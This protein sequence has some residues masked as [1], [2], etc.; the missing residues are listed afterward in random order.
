MTTDRIAPHFVPPSPYAASIWSRG[1]WLY[2]SRATEVVM[3]STIKARRRPA[4]NGER[5]KIGAGTLNIQ[6]QSNQEFKD[7]AQPDAF[8]I[9]IA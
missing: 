4:I 3:G 6:I 9:R 5:S 1:A 7:F 2:T 8:G